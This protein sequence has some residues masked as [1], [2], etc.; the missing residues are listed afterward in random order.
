MHPLKGTLELYAIS[1][2]LPRLRNLH[3]YAGVSPYR[4]RRQSSI[5]LRLQG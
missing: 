4:V 3:R 1:L 5:V 2:Q